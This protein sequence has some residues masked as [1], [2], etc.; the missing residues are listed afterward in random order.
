MFIVPFDHLPN[1]LRLYYLFHFIDK[2]TEVH[3]GY[4]T[5]PNNLASKCWSRDSRPRLLNS[6]LY[7]N[8][9]HRPSKLKEISVY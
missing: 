4:K 8:K 7:A 2:E 5:C 3:K 1:L 6:K 9:P